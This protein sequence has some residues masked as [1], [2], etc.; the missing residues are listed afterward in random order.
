LTI[1]IG[2]ASALLVFWLVRGGILD[3]ILAVVVAI[4]LVA[5]WS[6]TVGPRRSTALGRV[7]VEHGFAPINFAPDG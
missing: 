5:I 3:W 1:V 7:W 2:I 4:V 6:R